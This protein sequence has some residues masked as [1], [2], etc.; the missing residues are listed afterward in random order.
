MIYRPTHFGLEEL[1]DKKTFEDHGEN[2][3]NLLDESLLKVIDELREAHGKPVYCNNW[4]Q[5]GTTQWR[6]YRPRYCPIGAPMSMHRK[7]MAFDL[8]LEGLTGE[9]ARELV[10]KLHALGRLQGIRRIER[11]VSWLHID[12]KATGHTEL[13]EFDP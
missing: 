1:V 12:S 11:K 6:G 5:G 8:T 4:D 7:G 10:R 13:V 9:Q 3:W 2:A